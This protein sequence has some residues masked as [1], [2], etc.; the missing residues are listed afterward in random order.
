MVKQLQ[1]IFK[2]TELQ[3]SYWKL[4]AWTLPFVAIFILLFVNLIGLDDIYRQLVVTI[5]IIFF[6]VSVFWW[7]WTLHKILIIINELNRTSDRFDEVRVELEKTRQEITG[8][9]DL[10]D[11]NRKRRE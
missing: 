3:V 8:A 1:H 2:Q 11:S 7:W 9:F 4:A 5:S 6:S 10:N